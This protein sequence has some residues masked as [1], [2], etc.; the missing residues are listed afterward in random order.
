MGSFLMVVTRISERLVLGDRA[1][2]R[3]ASERTDYR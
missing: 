2:D 1:R 3:G